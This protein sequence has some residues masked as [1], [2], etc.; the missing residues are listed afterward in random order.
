[1][2]TPALRA[3]RESHR[4]A[5][6]TYLQRPFLADLLNGAPWFDSVEHWPERGKRRGGIV[7][8]LRRLRLAAFDT[9]ILFQNS[10]RSALVARLAGVRRRI[11]YS[12]EARGWLLTDR[13]LPLKQ[14]REFMPAPMVDYYR[15]LVGAAGCMVSDPRLQLIATP[16]DEAQLDKRLAPADDRPLLVLNP[17]ASYGVAKCWLA[18]RYVN[19]AQRLAHR[20]GMRIIVTCGPSERPVAD[21]IRAAGAS[22]M[23]IFIDPP[24]GLGP[25]KALVRRAA[26]LITNDTGTRHFAAAFDR[27][28]VTI[29]GS[30][31]P[32]WTQTGH[33]RE[34]QV[35]VKLDCQPCMRR[36]CPLGHH[37]CMKDVSVEMV[38][39]AAEDL[40]APRR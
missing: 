31:D 11:G 14:G 5:H 25:L 15:A 2:A 34:R 32:A 20:H 8:L 36:V 10:F 12:R 40:L 17:G 19:V 35:M 37:N 30:S 4:L 28:V 3:I 21:A 1:M 7:Q 24:L 13:L 22:D 38:E 18:D 33:A 26:L 39:R 29:F 16:D 6:I 9:A 23:T 27:P